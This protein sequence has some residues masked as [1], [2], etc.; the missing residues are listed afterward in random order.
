MI[1]FNH[2]CTMIC[3]NRQHK[4]AE[5]IPIAPQLLQFILFVHHSS[6]HR[7]IF[8]SSKFSVSIIQYVK[9]KVKAFRKNNGRPALIV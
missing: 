4:T 9:A 7:A 5:E 2:H 3:T 1:L 8:L 6:K